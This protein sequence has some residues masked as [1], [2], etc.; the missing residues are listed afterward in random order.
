[1]KRHGHLWPDIIDRQ[2]LVWAAHRAARGKRG[3]LEVRRFWKDFDASIDQLR[4]E[5]VAGTFVVGCFNTFKVFDPK[6]RTIHA[7]RFVERVFHHALMRWCE[8]ILDRRLIHHTY[9]CRTGKGRLAALETA[10][11]AMR[12][13]PWYLQM[14]VRKYFESIDHGVLL[15]QLRRVFKDKTLLGWFER[16]IDSHRLGDAGKGLPIGSLTSQHFANHYLGAIDR[17]AENSSSVKAYVR[18]MDDFVC[19]GNDAGSLIDVGRRI[20]KLVQDDLRLSLK[21]VAQPRPS[22]HGISLLGWRVFPTHAELN[23]R[24]RLRFTRK[25]RWLEAAWTQGAAS[26]AAVQQRVTALTAFTL[27]AKSFH[28]RQRCLSR[29]RCMAIGLEPGEPGWQLE[30]QCAELPFRQPQQQ[31]PHEPQ[32]QHR[33]PPCPKLRSDTLDGVIRQLQGTEPA[34]DPLAAMDPPAATN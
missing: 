10:Q 8:P 26:D 18:Y 7:A 13:Y 6:E 33:L 3:K 21:H 5:L 15:H 11:R 1:M 12:Q 34:M 4:R 22:R 29:F 23:R 17:F 19:W 31:H 25:M 27:P 20:E 30:Q 16:I 2:N 14:D 24:S 9:A 32:Q 28:W